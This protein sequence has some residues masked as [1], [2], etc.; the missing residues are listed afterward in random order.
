[1][2]DELET[3]G[4]PTVLPPPDGYE[5]DQLEDDPDD[6][7]E[8][9]SD[10]GAAGPEFNPGDG[11]EQPTEAQKREFEA[12]VGPG[13]NP[14]SLEGPDHPIEETRV[15]LNPIDPDRDTRG[16]RTTEGPLGA[17]ADIGSIAQTLA[18]CG[19][20]IKVKVTRL[21]PDD[22]PVQEA[23][24]SAWIDIPGSE[25]TPDQI[26]EMIDK[27]WGGGNYEVVIASIDPQSQRAEKVYFPIQGDWKPSTMAGHMYFRKIYGTPY[28]SGD[29]KQMG[30]GMQLQD[31]TMS[32]GSSAMM[33]QLMQMLQ[34][35][36]NAAQTRQDAKE[37][38]SEAATASVVSSVV[39]AMAPQR[40]S[41][42]LV[43]LV[44]ALSPLI[45][46]FVGSRDSKSREDRE[47]ML[48]LMERGR[49]D[50]G[51]Q[52][53]MEAMNAGVSLV[54]KQGELALEQSGRQN[55]ILLDQFERQFREANGG[56][57][58]GGIVGAFSHMIREGGPGLLESVGPMLQSFAA[59][60][61]QPAQ[62]IQAQPVQ[63]RP[64]QQQPRLPQQPFNQAP[65]QA[66]RGPTP[67][68]YVPSDPAQ[69]PAPPVQQERPVGVSDE[70]RQPTPEQVGQERALM[71]SKLFIFNA[72]TL[73]FSGADPDTS[74]DT[75]FEEGATMETFFG[76]M[77]K[78][79]RVRVE[80]PFTTVGAWVDGAVEEE[81]MQIVSEFDASLVKNAEVKAWL[82]EFLSY[83]PWTEPDDEDDDLDEDIDS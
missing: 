32:M 16:L 74:W 46:A 77:P 4:T 15:N 47:M 83:G 40:Q 65:V 81:L 48:N 70:P 80:Q 14:G 50:T 45:V 1:M 44:A 67:A 33:M 2:A 55:R 79:V 3:P 5:G 68:H 64:A 17:G 36:N 56:D 24:T 9:G 42:N 78:V 39:T 71:S 18:R 73:A 25:P 52:G 75:P 51:P 7:E 76:G 66:E 21:D 69:Q 31:E 58:P 29:G 37:L 30:G 8:G 57:E 49:G 11:S 6:E 43:E 38:S 41:L 54:R 61:P 19:N 35:Q 34:N 27:K 20:Q 72:H 63:G 62:P 22:L 82:G 26:S 28:V 53:M 13:F 23:A 10:A 60:N 59:R 12:G